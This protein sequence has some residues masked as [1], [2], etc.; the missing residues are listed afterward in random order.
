MR[1]LTVFAHPDPRSF[2]R[3]LLDRFTAGLAQAGHTVDLVDLY[4]IRFN[5]VYG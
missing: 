3:A 1:V 2:C 4:R 5:P